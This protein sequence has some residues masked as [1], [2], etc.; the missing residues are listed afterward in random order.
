[1]SSTQNKNVEILSSVLYNI[2]KRNSQ[3]IGRCTV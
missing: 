1:M 3:T 2:S